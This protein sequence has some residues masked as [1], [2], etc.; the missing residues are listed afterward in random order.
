MTVLGGN[1][2]GWGACVVGIAGALGLFAPLANARGAQDLPREPEAR[3]ADF[4]V[5]L[6]QHGLDELLL[7]EL[8]E[9]VTQKT[10]TA[11]VQAAE[12]LGR[13][14][15]RMLAEAPAA[16]RRELEEQSRSLLK[17]VPEA[18]GFALRLDLLKASY[19][20]SEEMA[21]R[22]RLRLT[23]AEETAEAQRSFRDLLDEFR[24]VGNKL[25][26]RVEAA[27]RRELSTR[28]ITEQM[29]DELNE[30]RRLRSLAK[31]YSGWCGYYLAAITKDPT[32]A[33]EALTQFGSILNAPS[34][35]PPTVDRVP[36]SLLK[37]EH[38]ARAV[39][40]VA[41]CYAAQGATNDALV[42]LGIVDDEGEVASGVRVQFQARRL[43]VLAAAGRWSQ[44]ESEWRHAVRAAR[45]DAARTPSV[46]TARLLAV[47]S[48]EFIRRSSPGPETDRAREVAEIALGRLIEAGELGH[49]V[50]LVTKYGT[51]PI[52]E[53]GFVVLYVRAYLAYDKVRAHHRAAVQSGNRAANV[54]GRESLSA[55]EPTRDPALVAEYRQ[56]AGMLSSA[57]GA[58]DRDKYPSER[59]RV[60]LLRGLALYYAGDAREAS[61][62]F[63]Q[64]ASDAG[65]ETAKRDALWYAIVTRD[66]AARAGDSAQADER[67]RLTTLFIQ[68]YPRTEQAA[69]LLLRRA[70]AG[71][72]PDLDAVDVLLAVA[73]DAPL[74]DAAQ[75][76]A[77][78]LLF[79]AYRAAP[80]VQRD[81][82]AQRFLTLAES[83]RAEARQ[84]VRD[85][86]ER[87]AERS[88]EAAADFVVLSRQIAEVALSLS[89]PDLARA[90][91]VV[92]EL[93]Q[94]AMSLGADVESLRG[95]L[96][97][98]R[99]QAAVLARQ[100]DAAAE[101]QRQLQELPKADEFVAA[102]DRVAYRE[103]RA[104][105]YSETGA[106]RERWLRVKLLEAAARVL[107][108][109]DEQWTSRTPGDTQ[110]VAVL[111]T[112]AQTAAWLH[113]ENGSDVEYRDLALR[114]DERA[115]GTGVR[116]VTLLRRLGRLAEEADRMSLALDAW[117][118]LLAGLPER[119]TSWFEAR[120]E[121]L[122]ILAIIDRLRAKDVAKQHAA[123]YP[124]R[125]PAPWGERIR[126]LEQLLQTSG[127][128]PTTRRA[129]IDPTSALQPSDATPKPS[130]SADGASGGRP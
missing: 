8:R 79:R 19:L 22:D 77:A 44:V 83:L 29:R 106:S 68:Q 17:L 46:A 39:L 101:L 112:I 103:L 90:R 121:S 64:A 129:R 15:V 71:L 119:E 14:Y 88:R 125:G 52:G 130:D 61:D 97:Y 49:V 82:I 55:D 5:Y 120:Y 54:E 92:D 98:R 100:W 62:A 32:P 113:D 34:G 48:L 27:E 10:G 89:V 51:A 58:E 21:E 57:A 95:E 59:A 67:D 122:R 116:T 47:E 4:R 40:G 117:R 126:A 110:I 38:M 23:T 35:K 2:K 37:Y 60:A 102:A 65:D 99:F 31:Y 50:D 74:R 25:N 13:Q 63:E 118:T 1:L 7:L 73:P 66:D 96:T 45:E 30:V 3:D 76:Q 42:W 43:S 86:Q 72:L 105:V 70:G 53:S 12:E 9:Q 33:R 84:R 109:L 28:E 94:S 111:E 78:A 91:E 36:R 56:A 18:D 128:I 41:L 6:K 11:R 16:R 93:E 107:A 124:E 26:A 87:S 114:A 24:T 108:R 81:F 20:R 104:V 127:E 69:R 123:L 80:E 75:R 85:D 115:Y